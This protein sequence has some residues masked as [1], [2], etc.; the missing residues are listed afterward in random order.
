MEEPAA[1]S[2]HEEETQPIL[3]NIIVP[4]KLDQVQA[5]AVEKR[6][7]P[8]A[9]VPAPAV[10][11]VAPSVSFKDSIT[12]FYGR[13]KLAIIIGTI[14]LLIFIVVLYL[15]VRNKRNKAKELHA[16]EEAAVSGP[17]P[18]SVSDL[19]KMRQQHLARTAAAEQPAPAKPAQPAPT[20]PAPV[21]QQQAAPVKQPAAPQQAAEPA[22]KKVILTE[23]A[24]LPAEESTNDDI[25]EMIKELDG[26]N[27]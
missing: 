23:P 21:K 2:D 8:E 7:A 12:G 3:P 10:P 6:A 24:P 27:E 26:S 20:K 22:P 25:E 4:E 13:N 5:P 11:D 15:Y 19:A 9:P 17:P 16:A 14:T 18:P 1:T